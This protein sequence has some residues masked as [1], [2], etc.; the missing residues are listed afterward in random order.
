MAK[1]HINKNGVPAICKAKEGQCPL[2]GQS[3]SENHYDTSQE[4]QVAADKIN[5]SRYG[6]L[7]DVNHSTIDSLVSLLGD[8]HLLEDIVYLTNEDDLKTINE[9]LIEEHNLDDYYYGDEFEQTLDIAE[10]LSH[11]KVLETIE[12][13]LT[14]E[15][16][17]R[18]SNELDEKYD[19]E[20]LQNL[21]RNLSW[22]LR[23]TN[24]DLFQSKE[25]IFNDYEVNDVD[26]TKFADENLP[27][28]TQSNSQSN[29]ELKNIFTSYG[30]LGKHRVQYYKQE[31]INI[32]A[33]DKVNALI[34]AAE[35]IQASRTV[36]SDE[37][38][39]F[40]KRIEEW[41]K[42]DNHEYVFNDMIYTMNNREWG[43]DNDYFN[44]ADEI[45]NIDSK[46]G[47]TS[48]PNAD[49]SKSI[50]IDNEGLSDDV[51]EKQKRLIENRQN[52]YL[53]MIDNPKLTE[54]LSS[55]YNGN[56][57]SIN[58][59]AKSI[60]NEEEYK[61]LTSEK[62]S[63]KERWGRI[64]NHGVE[65]FGQKEFTNKMLQRHLDKENSL[66]I[67]DNLDGSMNLDSVKLVS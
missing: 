35:E 7:N 11:Q 60:F 16:L 5:E 43:K 38:D 6:L 12:E 25:D 26:L 1:Y 8:K 48:G 15:D 45:L 36:D 13:K 3:G 19:I 57:S 62:G 46:E 28:S 52:L 55:E 2:G 21:Q 29:P 10:Q 42:N 9:Q 49:K 65:K 61:A 18:I 17:S 40:A 37:N 51:I 27:T 58:S 39:G 47:F 50:Y 56:I 53:S 22:Q 23:R 34:Q 59:F 4:A 44:R 24:E 20:E 32:K 30:K 64:Y 14:N 67:L 63:L 54:I 33:E 41:K 31:L 66:E